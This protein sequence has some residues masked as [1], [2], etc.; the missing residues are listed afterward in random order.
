MI[1]GSSCVF[2]Q[3]LDKKINNNNNEPAPIIDNERKSISGTPLKISLTRR[4]RRIIFTAT[5]FLPDDD[6]DDDNSN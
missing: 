6:D 3:A 5:I 1:N 2:N 4:R